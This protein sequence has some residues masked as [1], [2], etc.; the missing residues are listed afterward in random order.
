M[1]KKG[2]CVGMTR[3]ISKPARDRSFPNSL[4]VRFPSARHHEHVQVHEQDEVRPDHLRDEH[5]D[6]QDPPAGRQGIAARAQDADALFVGP[7]VQ[8]RFQDV[9]VGA[10][11]N[12]L[13]E[14]A[15]LERAAARG[16]GGLDAFAGRVADV[17]QVED[18]SLELRMPPE[19][20]E[21][22]AAVPA[23]DVHHGADSG[24]VVGLELARGVAGFSSI[25]GR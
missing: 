24:E 20:R 14:V 23:A 8:D 21:G 1:R 16:A 19:D 18:L 10:F 7:V 5:L 25:A 4:A 2:L 15:G 17:R 3:A 9:Q 12:G 13:E 6:D 22:E 11:R